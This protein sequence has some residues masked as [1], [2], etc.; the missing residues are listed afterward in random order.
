ME[1]GVGGYQG[2]RIFIFVSIAHIS[3]DT[4]SARLEK[5]IKKKEE[6]EDDE[7]EKKKRSWRK[8]T[9]KD[10]YLRK[11][12]GVNGGGHLQYG[13]LNKHGEG[14]RKIPF[15]GLDFFS[16]LEEDRRCTSLR[17]W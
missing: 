13:E 14:K 11:N 6:D 2:G 16:N 10:K 9:D 3:L 8:N 12:V 17:Y 1:W 7:D 5:I 4:S 15:K